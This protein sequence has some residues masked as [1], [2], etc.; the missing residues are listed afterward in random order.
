MRF[1]LLER[2]ATVKLLLVCGEEWSHL[3]PIM[4]RLGVVKGSTWV[5][6]PQLIILLRS[7]FLERHVIDFDAYSFSSSIFHC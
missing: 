1:R 5:L 2:I 7:H 4:D 3:G 6:I